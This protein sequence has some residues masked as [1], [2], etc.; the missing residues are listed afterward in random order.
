MCYLKEGRFCSINCVRR[1]GVDEI[2]IGV[3]W[4]G[5]VNDDGD[6]SRH[7]DIELDGEQILALVN[8]RG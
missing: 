4:I 3:S 2:F 5:C 7:L 8:K 6:E 1:E